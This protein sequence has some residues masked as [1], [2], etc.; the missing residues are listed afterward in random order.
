MSFKKFAMPK[1]RIADDKPR[2][3]LGQ[4]HGF[5]SLIRSLR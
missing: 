3:G 5:Q 1:V 4:R 2:F